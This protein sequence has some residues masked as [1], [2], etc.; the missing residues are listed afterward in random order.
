MDVWIKMCL[1]PLDHWHSFG[2]SFEAQTPPFLTRVA[3]LWP[4]RP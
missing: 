4:K 2:I 1:E 3:S